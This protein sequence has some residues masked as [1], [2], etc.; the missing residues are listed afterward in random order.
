MNIRS[1]SGLRFGSAVSHRQLDS[2]MHKL[3][4]E[5]ANSGGRHALHYIKGKQ[6]IPCPSGAHAREIRDELLGNI[7]HELG[8]KPHAFKE[9]VRDPKHHK[10]D[11][12]H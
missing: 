3:G 10:L 12:R 8:V 5:M 9:F 2:A 4:F 6:S 1:G 11:V 7:A